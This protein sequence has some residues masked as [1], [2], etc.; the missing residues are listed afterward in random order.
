MT[1]DLDAALATCG[2]HR[3]VDSLVKAEPDRLVTRSA[4]P[5]QAD[6]H[7]TDGRGRALL[8]PGTILLEHA[9]QSGEVLIHGLRGRPPDDGIPVLARVKRSAFRSPVAPG[10]TLTT[11]VRLVERVGPAYYV[12]AVGFVD[13]ARVFEADLA[14]TATRAIAE[15]VGHPQAPLV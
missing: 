10:A 6:Y 2:A 4:L 12:S 14:F 9:V 1:H 3:L 15:R 5:E 8:V 11:E 13:G 7:R